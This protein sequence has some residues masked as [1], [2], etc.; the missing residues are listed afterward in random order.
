MCCWRIRANG[1]DAGLSSGAQLAACV[2]LRRWGRPQ[3]VTN[4]RSAVREGVVADQSRLA[5]LAKVTRP[6][7]TQ[8]MSL[9]YLA[10]D[11]PE[12]FPFLALVTSGKD[13]IHKRMLRLPL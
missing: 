1:V 6:R 3:R 9:L 13:P 8:N 11:I 12:E 4:I 7:M 10:S 5:R 2:S